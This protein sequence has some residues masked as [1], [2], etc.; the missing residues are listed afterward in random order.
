[1]HPST[2]DI[3]FQSVF[4]A[5]YSGL[6]SEIKSLLLP[7]HLEELTVGPSGGLPAEGETAISV[8]RAAHSGSGSKDKRRNHYTDAS[9]WSTESGKLLLEFKGLRFSE[10]NMGDDADAEPELLVPAW[11]PDFEFLSQEQILS[12]L[13]PESAVSGLINLVAF[14]KPTLRVGEINLTT[15]SVSPVWFEGTSKCL[16]D[17]SEH[18]TYADPDSARLSTVRSGAGDRPNAEFK[19]L[20]KDANAIFPD[21]GVDLVI[22]QYQDLAAAAQTSVL[23]RIKPSE[24]NSDVVYLFVQRSTTASVE[25][26]DDAQL[27]DA[28]FNT[29]FKIPIDGSSI[30]YLARSIELATPPPEEEEPQ[31]ISIISADAQSEL[32]DPLAN[33]LSDS[34]YAVQLQTTFGAPTTDVKAVVVLDDFSSPVLGNVTDDQWESI[35]D[36]V[37]KAPSTLWVTQGAQHKVS[38]PNN[39]LIHGLARSIRSENPAVR[40]VTLDVESQSPQGKSATIL[41]LLESIASSEGVSGDDSEFV[42][43]NGILHVSRVLRKA[44]AE[45]LNV[46]DTVVPDSNAQSLYENAK[47]VQLGITNLGSLDT[48]ELYEAINEESPLTADQVEIELY[49]TGLNYK[50][51][52][53]SSS[54]VVLRCDPC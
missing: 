9:V 20:G 23:E 29:L 5:L 54:V 13:R 36:L 17:A 38:N 40:L 1:M 7:S 25:D 2:L 24:S 30:A 21:P 51:C 3:C 31:V 53:I 43:R 27:Q 44:D 15:D 28:G 8:A 50:V 10:L 45:E 22:V 46:D 33:S 26:A 42:E 19:L 18:Y 48:L 34:G 6:R 37:V 14:K 11:L 4:P 49:A 47:H 39:A 16:R 52:W 12:V 41:Q 35:R 32:L